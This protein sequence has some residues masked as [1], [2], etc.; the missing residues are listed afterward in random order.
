MDMLLDDV[1]NL[2]CGEDGELYNQIAEELSKFMHEKIPISE[3]SDGALACWTE[4]EKW[5]KPAQHHS[6]SLK[7]IPTIFSQY[8]ST[9]SCFA[10][11]FIVSL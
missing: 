6:G 5:A 11:R 9:E 2:Y 10:S 4:Y 7:S 1:L 3:L 8:T